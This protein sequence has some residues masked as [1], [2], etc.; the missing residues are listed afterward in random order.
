MQNRWASRC[1]AL[2]MVI[3]ALSNGA[4]AQVEISEIMAAPSDRLV[5]W[6]ADGIPRLGVGIPWTA[7]A[8]D[9]SSWAQGPAPLGFG[10]AGIATTV[11]LAAEGLISLYLRKTFTVSAADAA[12]SQPLELWIKYDDA[13][14]AYLNGVEL[15]REALGPRHGVVYHDQQAYWNDESTTIRNRIFTTARPASELLVAGENV[16]TLQIHNIDVDFHHVDVAGKTDR[17][18]A[19]ADLKVQGNVAS[20]VPMGS[21]WKYFPGAYEPSGG[22]GDADG[23]WDWIELTNTSGGTVN[24]TGWSLTDDATDI[25]KWVFPAFSLPAGGRVVVFASGLDLPGPPMHTNFKLSKEGEYLGLYNT[26][27]LVVSEFAPQFPPQTHFQS[28]G[29]D[30]GGNPVYFETPTPGAANTGVTYAGITAAP[31]FNVATGLFDTAFD[32][33]LSAAPGASVRYFLYQPTATGA[34]VPPRWEFDTDGDT[35]GWQILHSTTGMS[36]SGGFLNFSINGPDPY[37]QGPS[38]SINAAD[39][40]YLSLRMKTTETGGGEF[41]FAIPSQ[42]YTA[43]KAVRFTVDTANQW[44]DYTLDM[45]Q[46]VTAGL[47]TGTISRLR[48]D[49]PGWDTGQ[50]WIDF[51]RLGSAPDFDPPPPPDPGGSE[52]TVVGRAPTATTGVVYDGTPVSIDKNT[53]VRAIAVEPGYLPSAVVTQSYIF[54]FGWG[55]DETA[56]LHA[57][58]I[59]SL[60]ADEERELYEPFGGMAVQSDGYSNWWTSGIAP[61][62]YNLFVMHGRPFE[63]PIHM[64]WIEPSDGSG[65]QVETGFRGGRSDVGRRGLQRTDGNWFAGTARYVFWMHFRDDYGES[66]LVAPIFDPAASVNRFKALG[67]RSNAGDWI[68]PTITDELTRRLQIAVGA[69]GAW[70]TFANV[71]VNGEFKTYLFPVERLNEDF[72][73]YQFNSNQD[74]DVL[75]QQ[76][77]KDFIGILELKSGTYDAWDSLLSFAQTNDL[78]DYGN[79][80]EIKRRMDVEQFVDWLLISI[81][82]NIVD[83]PWNNWVTARERSPQGKFRWYAW[84][85]DSAFQLQVRAIDRIEQQNVDVNRLYRALKTSYEF[86]LLWQDRVQRHF[87]YDGAL[88]APKVLAIHNELKSF[89]EP[90]INYFHNQ[91]FN[92]Y[93]ADDWIPNRR[94]IVFDQFAEYGYAPAIDAPTYTELN[95]TV[96]LTN[97]NASGTIYYTLDGKDPRQR[98]VSQSNPTVYYA[99]VPTSDIGTAWRGG[100]AF[101]HSSWASGTVGVGYERGTGYG[102]LFDIDVESAMYGITDN[103]YVRVPFNVDAADLGSYVGMTLNIRYDDAFVAYLN[104]TEIYRVGFNGEPAWNTVAD[105]SNT[106]PHEASSAFDTFDVSQHLGLLHAGENILAIHGLNYSATG[107][108]ASSDFLSAAYLTLETNQVDPQY[109]GDSAVEYTAPVAKSPSMPLLARVLDGSTWSPLLAVDPSGEE[110]GLAN[111]RI[112]EIM[113]HPATG[114]AEFIEIQNTGAVAIN[115]GNVRFCDGIDFTFPPNTVLAPGQRL[116]L[117]E[118]SLAFEAAYPG[119][120][121][122]GVYAGRLSNGGERVA[123]CAPSGLAASA[124]TYSDSG[125]WPS[126]AD[127]QGFS[128]VLIDPNGDV[129]DPANWRASA[130][131]GGSPGTDEAAANI[132]AVYINEALTHTDPPLVDAIELYNPTDA[133]ADVRGWFLTDDRMVPIKARIPDRPEYIIPAGGYAVVD[134]TVFSQNPGEVNGTPMQGFLLSSHGEEVFLFSAD[135]ATGQ[136]TGYSQGE[137]FGAAENGVSFGR[138]VTSEGKVHFVAQQANTLGSA[139]AGP[140]VGPVVISE[141]NY[142]PLTGETEYLVVTNISSLQVPLWDHSSGGDPT[143]TYKVEGIGFAFEGQYALPPGTSALIVNGDPA[144]FHTPFGPFGNDTLDGVGA[145]DNGGEALELMWPDKPDLGFVPW[146][147]MDKVKYD[148]VAPWPT[149]ADGLGMSLHRIDP[150]A[151]GNDPANWTAAPPGYN[152]DPILPASMSEVWVDFDFVG[153]EVGTRAN[154]FGDLAQGVSVCQAGGTLQ[155][156]T[157]ESG[158]TPRIT[159]AMRINAPL[160]TV[161]IGVPAPAA[162]ST[163]AQV[164][165]E[166]RALL[167]ALRKALA[168]KEAREDGERFE[169]DEDS[170][171]TGAMIFEPVLPSAVTPEGYQAARPDSVLSIRLRGQAD[172]DPNSIWSPIPGYTGDQAHAEWMPVT[173]DGL[174]DVWVVFRP[175][176]RWYVD[177]II[178]LSVKAETVTGETLG[179]VEYA[180]QVKEGDEPGGSILWQPRYGEDLEPASLDLTGESSDTA[181]VS[182]AVGTSE[183]PLEEGLSSPFAIG[184][185]RVYDTPRRVW[186]PIPLGVDPASV[187]LYYY[188]PQGP[189]RGW[190]PAEEVAGWLVP[191]SELQVVIEGRTYL[192]FLVR[193]AGM[194]QLGIPRP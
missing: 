32:L 171:Q 59:I 111:L 101:D 61:D 9:D 34:G 162:K 60:V 14:V 132:P 20:L 168:G 67:L 175:E 95:D 136:L 72:F 113:Y 12:S 176:D 37:T 79:W 43:G 104:G 137:T 180:F 112:T 11:D 62:E 126:T 3:F 140:K 135:L 128:L 148:D 166:M 150:A 82:S 85:N 76:V 174:Q 170:L 19:D 46:T 152:N 146:I 118:D 161:R 16:L 110:P 33:D 52:P 114:G 177:D 158:D 80:L 193:H 73:Q 35:E 157:G 167:D 31:V 102:N 40:R 134:E 103:C 125:D 105:S 182:M 53:I 84:D 173:E 63:R 50:V 54:G 107:S 142:N 151:Y 51:I 155:I 138:H 69:C 120:S 165:P 55:G 192:G 154:P 130:V 122:F 27:G 83:W 164:S 88:T 45:T 70:G 5:R 15:E 94:Q 75:K 159:K 133:P 42:G 64:A 2:G 57:A 190:Y 178:K 131:V 169:A 129:N 74:W 116:I 156:K 49:P 48:F 179:P 10:D 91:A 18:F 149:S 4:T 47:W 30:S 24:M 68:N 141:I 13:F 184:P 44:V 143:N 93:I 139:N 1:I 160:S 89:M 71:F 66:P 117:V 119:V 38:I 172:I 109:L 194:V 28:Y 7:V 163:Q 90:I 108:H 23:F 99:Y 186:L 26:S 121:Y 183:A 6:D 147:L 25:N 56:A 127:G 181:V 17:V 92:N 58:P 189:N 144:P 8:Y 191:D 39:N 36:A 98:T 185:D 100:A 78:N 153:T 124:V 41:F 187:S 106:T 81:Y 21:T 145:L 97:P 188:H 77:S 65:F 86:R 96:Y 123:L 22:F 115:I 87:Y 29:F